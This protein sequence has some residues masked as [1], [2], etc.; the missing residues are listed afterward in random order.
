MAA[1][2]IMGSAAPSRRGRLFVAANAIVLL[3]LAF[4]EI[5]HI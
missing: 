4:L 3:G 2:L 5:A 1:A